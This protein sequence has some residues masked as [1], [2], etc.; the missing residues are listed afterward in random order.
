M[1]NDETQLLQ[2]GSSIERE[3]FSY[4]DDLAARFSSWNQFPSEEDPH[5]LYKFVSLE[6]NL[7]KDLIETSR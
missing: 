2:F 3:Y 6:V 7:N 4:Y 1:L 5:T